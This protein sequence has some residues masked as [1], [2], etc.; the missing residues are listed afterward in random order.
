M[1]DDE[2]I[3]R[4]DVVEPRQ[5]AGDTADEQAVEEQHQQRAD[6]EQHAAG[7]AA[8][9]DADVVLDVKAEHEQ[10]GLGLAL[11]PD[12]ARLGIVHALDAAHLRRVEQAVDRLV[13]EIGPGAGDQPGQH[14]NDE[15]DR[16]EE[17]VAVDREREIAAEERVQVEP[18]FGAVTVELAVDAEHELVQ[19][20]DQRRVV[21]ALLRDRQVLA[22][23]HVVLGQYPRVFGLRRLLQRM[24]DFEP[25][26]FMRLLEGLLLHRTPRK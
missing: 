19:A 18:G 21:K 10:V 15:G 3:K 4:L 5:V 22:Q 11:A 24:L 20:L 6:A 12:L 16:D 8:E 23:Q 14:E 26:G 1:A 9:R 7:E 13:V 25:G 2:R 17:P